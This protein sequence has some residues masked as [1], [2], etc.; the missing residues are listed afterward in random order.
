MSSHST[1]PYLIRAIYEWC[2]D[3]NY[4]PYLTAKTSAKIDLPLEYLGNDEI[5]LNISQ[6]AVSNLV[7]GNDILHF[8]ARFGGVSKTLQISIDSIMAIFAKEV[9]QG[10]TFVAKEEIDENETDAS[11]SI[12]ENKPKTSSRPNLQIIK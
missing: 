6:S 3:N 8:K 11:K 12:L 9:S 10:L 5:T 7:I 2:T 4:T 1:K